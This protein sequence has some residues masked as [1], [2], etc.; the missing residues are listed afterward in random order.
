M[1][2]LYRMRARQC[3]ANAATTQD[4]ADR[5]RLER[6]AWE[7]EQLAQQEGDDP[8]EDNVIPFE[9]FL[10]AR[11]RRARKARRGSGGAAVL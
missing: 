9:Q 4:P 11:E 7:W 6:I 3:R 2:E 10:E 5:Y 1:R 8:S